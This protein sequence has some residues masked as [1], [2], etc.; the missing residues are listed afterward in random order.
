MQGRLRSRLD[1]PIRLAVE[2]DEY[3]DAINGERDYFGPGGQPIRGSPRGLTTGCRGCGALHAF[4]RRTALRAGP[5]PPDP[6]VVKP[7]ASIA[8]A[9]VNLSR[10]CRV[11]HPGSCPAA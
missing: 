6:C 11:F 3:T 10:G 7:L 9:A 5:A 1:E 4:V 8:A 2:E